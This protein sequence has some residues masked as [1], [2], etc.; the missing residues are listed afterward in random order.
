M[1]KHITAKNSEGQPCR[2]HYYDRWQIYYSTGIV[3]LP[4]RFGFRNYI[5]SNESNAK[6]KQTL[7]SARLATFKT[8]TT[9]AFKP[10]PRN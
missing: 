6:K 9:N 1:R 4:R 8:L 5:S 10:P 3:E 2:K 7:F